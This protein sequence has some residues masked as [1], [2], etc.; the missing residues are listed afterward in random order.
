MQWRVPLSIDHIR[1]GSV[2]DQKVDHGYMS[3]LR[4]YM[5]WG[6]ACGVAPIVEERKEVDVK[7]GHSQG[8]R[9]NVLG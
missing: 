9:V 2:E 8:C 6:L 5:E 4:G 7:L 1:I 3:Q